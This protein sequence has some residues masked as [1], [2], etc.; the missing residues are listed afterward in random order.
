MPRQM[1]GYERRDVKMMV[2]NSYS[3]LDTT[4]SALQDILRTGDVLVFNNSRMIPSSLTV[5]SER[6]DKFLTVNIGTDRMSNRFLFEVRPR[7]IGNELTVGDRLKLTGESNSIVLLNRDS[8]FQRYWWGCLEEEDK[9]IDQIISELGRFIRYDHIPFDIPQKMYRGIFYKVPG[10]VELPSASYS[11]DHSLLSGLRNKGIKTVELT[12]HCNLGSLEPAEFLT[13]GRLLKERYSV[14]YQTVKHVVEAKKR[15]KRVIAVGTTV[16]RALEAANETLGEYNGLAKF[17]SSHTSEDVIIGET[18]IYIDE[19][20]RIETI[21]GIITG[22]H[23]NEGSHIK[24]LEAFQKRKILEKVAMQAHKWG[25]QYH[26]FG[27]LALIFLE[28]EIKS[29]A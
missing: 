6:L 2:V 27:D 12:L 15:G 18:D 11:F 20:H 29:T 21:N 13:R 17:V 7:G 4:L 19:K 28:N 5:Y 22:M 3:I 8:S 1:Y 16:V 26:E 24:M 25:Y 9:T 10:S 23:E 14:P